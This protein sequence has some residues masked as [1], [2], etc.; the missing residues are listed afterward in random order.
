LNSIEVSAAAQRDMQGIFDYTYEN[1]GREQVELYLG[2]MES[3]FR[4]IAQRPRIGAPS[5]RLSPGLRRLSVGH[6][7]IFYRQLAGRIRIE[8]VLH[9][10]QLPKVSQ[11]LEK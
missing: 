8:R 1:W 4:L 5:Y 2:A 11:V 3:T 10:R 6:H 7:V 9:E